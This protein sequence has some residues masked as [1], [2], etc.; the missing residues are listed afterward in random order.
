VL[1]PTVSR[2][3]ER[4]LSQIDQLLPG[5]VT[6]FY[7][8]GSVALGAYREGRSDI[9]FVAVIRG[10]LD[11]PELVRLR[12]QH[13]RSGVHTSV[14]AIGRRQSPLAGTC[15]GVF[16]RAADIARPVSDIVPVAAHCGHEFRTGFGGS[17]VSPVAWKVLAEHGIALR[18][19]APGA[20]P[21]DPQP[22]LLSSWNLG[23]LEDYWRPWA[24]SPL[25][26][27]R[28]RPRWSTAW[29]VLGSPRL[30][31]TIATGEVISKEAAGEYALDVFDARWQPL[32]RES[33]AYVRREPDRL[34]HSPEE[35]R[36]GTSEFVLEVA[37]DARRV[38]S[39]AAASGNPAEAQH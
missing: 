23:N 11:R 30:H 39:S 4:Y 26:G 27:F 20:L 29:G 10:G 13:A 24:T 12:M 16:I 2:A 34:R 25:R 19:V 33:L 35:R 17:D 15:N 36:R 5:V 7:I 9:D 37:D 6:G 3:V 38:G 14:R 28:L 31:A 8:V 22:E 32:I 18:G 21:L 1:P